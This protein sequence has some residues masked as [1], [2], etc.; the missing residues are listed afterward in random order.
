MIRLP[1][2][3]LSARLRRLAHRGTLGAPAHDYHDLQEL[4]DPFYATYPCRDAR[5]L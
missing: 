2:H 5:P 4:L 3:Y 1:E